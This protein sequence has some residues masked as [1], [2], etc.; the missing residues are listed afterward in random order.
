MDKQ[1]GSISLFFS[2]IMAPLILF[3]VCCV[4]MIN[5]ALAKKEVAIVSDSVTRSILAGYDANVQAYGLYGYDISES[6]FSHTYLNLFRLQL[7]KAAD[8][9]MFHQKKLGEYDELKMQILKEMEWR[10][11]ISWM[12]QLIQSMQPL[13]SKASHVQPE[14]I[15]DLTSQIESMLNKKILLLSLVRTSLQELRLHWNNTRLI[16][17]SKFQEVLTHLQTLADIEKLLRTMSDRLIP[18]AE[19]K[20]SYMQKLN[21]DLQRIVQNK[22]YD[23]DAWFEKTDYELLQMATDANLSQTKEQKNNINKTLN[24][25]NVL[26]NENCRGTHSSYEKLKKMSSQH[27]TQSE[28]IFMPINANQ[29]MNT[30][31]QSKMTIE[32]MT[33]FMKRPIS[34]SNEHL[35]IS[36]FVLQ[37]FNHKQSHLN[38]S[39]ELSLPESHVLRNQEVEYVL[40]GYDNCEAN[41]KAVIAKLFMFR[42]ALRLAEFMIRPELNASFAMNPLTFIMAGLS[43]ATTKASIDTAHLLAGRYVPLIEFSIAS[44]QPVMFSYQDHLRLILWTI[45]NRTKMNRIQNLIALNT[46]KKLDHLYTGLKLKATF[47]VDTAIYPFQRVVAESTYRYE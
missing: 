14:Q 4:D 34:S 8:V 36:E 23:I 26:F 6:Q 32:M 13:D 2:I 20:P 15:V 46:G 35:L 5:V 7:D 43:Y 27:A 40:S 37:K 41:D 12:K 29:L 9:K 47:K 38:Q 31:K 11:P 25:M 10:A 1:T 22:M 17:E 21:D 45:P 16:S 30:L 44:L 19:Q 18:N 3:M 24:Q 42:I 33:E 39:T 28:K